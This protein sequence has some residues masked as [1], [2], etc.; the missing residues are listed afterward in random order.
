[1]HQLIEKCAEYNIPL[2]LAF[3][4]YCKAFDSVK[5]MT[6][7]IRLHKE[8]EPFKLEKG[9]RQGDYI[10]PKLFTV[11]LEQIFRKLNWEEMGIKIDSEIFNNLKFVDDIVLAP[12]Y[13]EELQTMLEQLNV[14]SKAVG[15]EI[16][17]SK[18]QVMFNIIDEN[19]Q[20]IGFS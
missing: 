2:C 1:M 9:K 10:S 16:N 19:D 20:R 5:N 15:L 3:V 12:E 4:D 14:E 8:S 18:I 7:F 13:T 6:S 11:C 17:L